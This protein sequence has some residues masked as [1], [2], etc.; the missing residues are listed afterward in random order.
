M[1]RPLGPHKLGRTIIS[2]NMPKT[3]ANAGNPNQNQV[4]KSL[5]YCRG[6]ACPLRTASRARSLMRIWIQTTGSQNKPVMTYKTT[7]S[8][9]HPSVN[10]YP[11]IQASRAPVTG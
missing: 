10:G 9:I 11:L 3:A 7:E 1:V 2:Q 4:Q 5:L 6:S 8:T